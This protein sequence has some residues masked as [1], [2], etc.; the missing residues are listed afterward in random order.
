MPNITRFDVAVSIVFAAEAVLAAGK[1][2]ANSII[3]FK[4]I[5]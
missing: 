2:R 5:Y 4:T 3:R 1:F